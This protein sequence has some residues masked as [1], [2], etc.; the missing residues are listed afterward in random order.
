ME[1][2][3]KYTVLI[4]EDEPAIALME[5]KKLEEVGFITE[6]AECGKDALQRLEKDGIDLML[7]DHRLPDMKGS[8]VVGALGKRVYSLPVVLITAF[9]DE[10][11][12]VEMFKSGVADYVIKD[13]DLN[14]LHLLPKIVH[15]QLEHYRMKIDL[16]VLNESLERR[17]IERTTEI[18]KVNEE[19]RTEIA[20]HKH[21]KE[22]LEKSFNL[23]N[24]VIEGTTDIVFVKDL[25]GRYL[26]VNS[27]VVNVIGKS[28][29]EI[30]GKDD[31]ELFSPEIARQFMESDQKIRTARE[32]QIFEEVVIV[33]GV[34]RIYLT[35]K[36]VRR[37][38][39]GNTIGIIGISRD[40]TERKQAE[41]KLRIQ[42]NII[43]CASSAIVTTDLDGTMKSCNPIFLE[44][45][46]FDETD[47]ILGRPFPEFWMVSDKLHEIMRA[48]LKEGHWSG[49]VKAKKKD[50]TLF[51]VQVSAATVY[52]QDGNPIRLMSSSVDITERKMAIEALQRSEEKY[53]SLVQAIPD[54]IYKIDEDG[55]FIF[56]NNSIR[57]LGYEPEEIIGKHFS[58]ILHPDDI[59]SC[60]RSVVLPKYSGKVTGDKETPKLFDERR[61]QKRMTRNLEVRLL[62]KNQ[63]KEKRDVKGRIGLITSFGEINATELYYDKVERKNKILRVTVGI[64]IDITEKIKLQAEMIRAGQ[65]ALIGEIAA[66][67]AHEINNPIYG[68]IN[69]AQL[70]ADESDKESRAHKFGKLIMGEGNRIADL[71]K[72]LLSLS[73][74][75]TGKKRP[76]QIYEL[77]SNSLK[78]TKVQLKKDNIIIKDNISKDIPAIIAN[79]QE[80]HQVFLNLIQNA[81]YALNEKYPD[82]D[83]DKILEISCNKVLIDDYEYARI[84]F[85]D[86]GIG[87]PEDILN[88]ITS[89]FFTTKPLT[90]GIGIGL[91]ISQN[92]ISNHD[93]KMTIESMPGQFTKVVIDLPATELTIKK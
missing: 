46:G 49:E 3:E 71:T 25:Q 84:I 85:Y 83:K 4:V 12:A 43:N 81:R 5:R 17:V 61:G 89:P 9:G 32:A 53:R 45:W 27:A 18:K 24:A 87:I 69:Y 75:T 1:V 8:E 65:L 36:G 44:M 16:K 90:N 93:G 82:K 10:H 51:D 40:I 19:L 48:L 23:L 38:N 56:L 63:D 22:E 26:M 6:V 66:G 28:K 64:I 15:S 34:N 29:E 62:P 14:F 72:K 11:L 52:N 35:K 58:I 59:E 55:H 86:R 73:R 13:D 60:S 57:T 37:D 7:L 21:T 92:I 80:I 77:I 91:S 2:K 67:I 88:K 33:E 68:I 54:I 31:K 50:G 76:V 47:E 20:K 78:L 70:I 42:D 30:I 74:S 41:E 39:R 79:P